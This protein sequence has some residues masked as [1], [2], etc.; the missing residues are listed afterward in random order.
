VKAGVITLDELQDTRINETTPIKYFDLIRYI[1]KYGMNHYSQKMEIRSPHYGMGFPL[2]LRFIFR[3][4][5]K[6]TLIIGC[7]RIIWVR[8]SI[9]DIGFRR[10]NLADDTLAPTSKV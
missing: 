3:S 2:S 1:T 6:A 4:P 5:A 8:K 10:R 7:S 9:K